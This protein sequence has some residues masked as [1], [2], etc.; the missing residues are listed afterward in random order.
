MESANGY[1]ILK[2]PFEICGGVVLKHLTC[3]ML[4]EDFV[5]IGPCFLLLAELTREVGG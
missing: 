3:G 4:A 2:I 1:D 5:G